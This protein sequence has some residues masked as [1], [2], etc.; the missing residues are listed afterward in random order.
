MARGNKPNNFIGK[1]YDVMTGKSK[2]EKQPVYGNER[3]RNAQNAAQFLATESRPTGGAQTHSAKQVA[4]DEALRRLTGQPER[5][6][7]RRQRVK[8]DK[9]RLPEQRRPPPDQ[10]R[11]PSR[12]HQSR[13]DG[14]GPSQENKLGQYARGAATH[15]PVGPAPIPAPHHGGSE[16]DSKHGQHPNAIVNQGHARRGPAAQDRTA[17]RNGDSRSAQD[18]YHQK[19]AENIVSLGSKPSANQPRYT[20]Y[21][22]DKHKS[23]HM[24]EVVSSGSPRTEISN[25]AADRTTVWADFVV[26]P[27]TPYGPSIPNAAKVYQHREELDRQRSVSLCQ[28]CRKNPPSK[29]PRYANL[30][31]HICT[32]CIKQAFRN[33]ENS[34][35][36]PLT[37][38]PHSSS[39]RLQ[40]FKFPAS[41]NG[42]D[43]R[44]NSYNS[45]K[46]NTRN[47]TGHSPRPV[48]HRR[49]ATLRRE[50]HESEIERQ[51]KLRVQQAQTSPDFNPNPWAKDT[52]QL[53]R[54]LESGLSP[55]LHQDEGRT[56]KI[57]TY[58]TI[59][60]DRFPTTPAQSLPPMSPPPL[61]ALPPL[62]QPQNPA[63]EQNDQSNEVS[64]IYSPTSP[65]TTLH[66]KRLSQSIL[67][68]ILPPST[69]TPIKAG[70]PYDYLPGDSDA[71]F[72]IPN[73]QPDC[74]ATLF[75]RRLT[76]QNP[77]EIEILSNHHRNTAQPQLQLPLLKPSVYRP[78]LNRASVWTMDWSE[79][80]DEI[81]LEVAG[82]KDRKPPVPA[83]PKLVGVGEGLSPVRD[84]VFYGFYDDI[85]N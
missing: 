19:Q 16:G 63:A 56:K 70:N 29:D 53:Q 38:G 6:H 11:Q 3:Q 17:V 73:A 31:Y 51:R 45:G 46:D 39:A 57:H 12:E 9:G 40:E 49:Q 26:S 22:G 80:D 71:H 27:I 64:S 74:S 43:S 21:E 61:K 48:L 85:V 55:A 15:A 33:P 4:Q 62:P 47:I 30:N 66:P 50:I 77:Q 5:A 60:N 67:P 65:N 69:I 36:S 37:P 79:Y 52:P 84:S 1:L 20:L 34:P 72:S 25:Q 78:P 41:V 81:R 83:M 59:L 75:P 24:S 14:T 32:Q 8:E 76:R 7:T 82:L 54:G 28:S 58:S 13:K 10:S 18:N 35:V 23:V 42:K 2:A 44:S 68:S